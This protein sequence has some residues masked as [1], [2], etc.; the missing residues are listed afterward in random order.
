MAKNILKIGQQSA[1]STLHN[2]LVN[3]GLRGSLILI[4]L[5]FCIVYIKTKSGQPIKIL[6]QYIFMV[7]MAKKGPKMAQTWA[8]LKISHN[9]VNF[10]YTV[11]CKNL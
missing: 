9:S 10:H 4:F 11:Y 5:T 6:H 8:K 2:N 1:K 3:L 7:K